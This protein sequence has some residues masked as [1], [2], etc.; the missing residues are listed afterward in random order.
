M[1]ELVKTKGDL[2]AYLT[3]NQIASREPPKSVYV[4]AKLRQ[5][6]LTDETQGKF[7]HK[8]CVKRFVFKNLGG[9]VYS[10]EIGSLS[11]SSA[12]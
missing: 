10:A 3:T 12:S 9:G 7:I 6:V 5:I 8:G 2:I 11:D 1:T 4:T